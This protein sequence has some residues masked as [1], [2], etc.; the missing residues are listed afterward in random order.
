MHSDKPR[1][2][3]MFGKGCVLAMKH[4]WGVNWEFQSPCA[5]NMFGKVRPRQRSFETYSSFQS[6]CAGNMFG[7]ASK[8][9]GLLQNVADLVSIPVCG[10][11]VW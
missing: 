9:A 8:E 6:P 1:A 2:G 3:N 5:G 10:E 7:K 4:V 11:H